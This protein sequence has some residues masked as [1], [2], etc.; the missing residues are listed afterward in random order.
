MWFMFCLFL[1]ACMF[2]ISL[3]LIEFV[4]KVLMYLQWDKEQNAKNN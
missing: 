3:A 2:I 4:I 1:A